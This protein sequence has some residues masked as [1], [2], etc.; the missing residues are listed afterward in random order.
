V[1]SYSVFNEIK[2]DKKFLR[3]VENHEIVDKHFVPQIFYL[4]HLFKYYKGKVK[5][6]PLSNLKNYIKDH[7]KPHPD[8]SISES[9]K[10][11]ILSIDKTDYVKDDQKLI[12]RYMGKTIDL[13]NIVKE[14]KYVL[15]SA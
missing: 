14:Y 6:Q 5:I 3:A 1:H 8:I 4:I 9:Q 7:K 13:I 10:Q 15:S 11:S 12:A 2:I